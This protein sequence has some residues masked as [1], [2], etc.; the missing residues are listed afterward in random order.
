M[1]KLYCYVDETGQDVGSKVFIV[2]AI[3]SAEDQEEIRSM[4]LEIERVARTDGLKWHKNTSKRRLQYLSLTFKKHIAAGHIYFGRYEKPLPYFFPMLEV[5]EKAIFGMRLKN[6]KASIIVDGIDNKKAIE[7][8]NALRL[9]GIRLAMVRS[10]RDESEPL[11]R[12]A[13]MWAGCI[14]VALQGDR[15]TRLL[16]HRAIKSRFIIEVT[17]KNN[18]P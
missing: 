5:I 15:Q 14:R 16:F 3:V 12:L 9:Q 1:T 11:I 6:Y 13:D 17:K 4:L 2:V 8:T 18:P 10:R 7:L